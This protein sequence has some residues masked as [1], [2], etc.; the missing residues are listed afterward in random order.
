MDRTFS[1]VIGLATLTAAATFA[2]PPAG[3]AFL[4]PDLA[5]ERRVDAAYT[6]GGASIPSA[7][8]ALAEADAIAREGVL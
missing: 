2:Q 4:N 8:I 6:M 7:A 3:A 5:P 1:L